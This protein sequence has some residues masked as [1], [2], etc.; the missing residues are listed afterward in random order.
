[1]YRKNIGRT[2]P[3]ARRAGVTLEGVLDSV[4]LGSSIVDQVRHL[5]G[6]VAVRDRFSYPSAEGPEGH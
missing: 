6:V 3:A 4:V 5:E 2:S 1:M